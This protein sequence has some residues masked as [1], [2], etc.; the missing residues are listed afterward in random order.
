M[1]M[2]EKC[3]KSGYQPADMFIEA[4]LFVGPCCND[5]RMTPVRKVYDEPAQVHVLRPPDQTFEYGVELSNRAGVKAYAS[6]GGL[7]VRFERSPEE[8]KKWAEAN[9][10]TLA[11]KS[12]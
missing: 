8:I 11:A 1:A 12:A 6:Y 7:E 2:C 9:G 10:F 4:N 5:G 3:K